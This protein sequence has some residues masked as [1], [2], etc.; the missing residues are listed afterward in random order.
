MPQ[1]NSHLEVSLLYPSLSLWKQFLED[2]FPANYILN[3]AISTIYGKRQ[4]TKDTIW[5]AR[6]DFYPFSRT[7]F[8]VNFI[9]NMHGWL[10]T[11][12]CNM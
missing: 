11:W 5:K 2:H 4:S 7:V 6:D 8:V 9:P 12:I 3:H 1:A 10:A